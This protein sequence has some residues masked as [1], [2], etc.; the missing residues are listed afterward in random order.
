M[1]CAY[2]KRSI[3]V[4]VTARNFGQIINIS[5]AHGLFGHAHETSDQSNANSLGYEL[6]RGILRPYEARV[7]WTNQSIITFKVI[8]MGL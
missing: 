3:E 6:T 7:Q 1:H 2:I 4:A 8:T 5:T